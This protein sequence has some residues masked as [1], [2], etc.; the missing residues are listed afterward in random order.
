MSS[1]A[2]TSFLVISDTHDLNLET[3]P[4]SLAF[5]KPTPQADVLLHCGD[6]TA[7]GSIESHQKFIKMLLSMP[8]ELK[9]VIAGIHDVDLNRAFFTQQGGE[10]AHHEQALALWHAPSTLDAGRSSIRL[11]KTGLISPE[12]LLGV[13]TW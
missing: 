10:V 11:M 13:R 9:L 8:A 5:R 3:S 7:N 12:P 6:L 1:H 4:D 2:K